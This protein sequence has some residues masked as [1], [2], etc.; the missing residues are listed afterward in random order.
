MH[1]SLSSCLGLGVLLAVFLVDDAHSVAI[2]LSV[3]WHRRLTSARAVGRWAQHAPVFFRFNSILA[4][5]K[6]SKPATHTLRNYDDPL[7][8]GAGGQ[9]SS[10]RA[11]Q[12]DVGT[13]P[14]ETSAEGS[15]AVG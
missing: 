12:S 10:V 2:V 4:A 7:Q 9:V 6:Q 13:L 14:C 8:E 11:C 15:S 5:A 3:S 1:R